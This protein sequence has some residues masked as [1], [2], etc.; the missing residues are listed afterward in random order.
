[1]YKI[2]LP[3]LCLIIASSVA[4]LA[5][6][7]A[8]CQAPM[9]VQSAC[10]LDFARCER[11]VRPERNCS[12]K[13]SFPGVK[14]DDP[15]CLA[16]QQSAV[17]LYEATKEQCRR[18]VSA[19][20]ETCLVE[21]AAQ[22]YAAGS[23]YLACL[24]L[25]SEQGAIASQLAVDFDRA[26][27]ELEKLSIPIAVPASVPLKLQTDMNALKLKLY[28]TTEM[29]R[30]I[31]E[32]RTPDQWAG[33]LKIGS[34]IIIED[35]IFVTGAKSSLDTYELVAATAWVKKFRTLGSAFFDQLASHRVQLESEVLSETL[36][37]CVKLRC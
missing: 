23:K 12:V 8:K 13:F 33:G 2:F 3:A 6:S 17:A 22:K 10:R 19:E 28:R 21:E 24:K 37:Q 36:T 1:M 25:R 29:P 5:Q 15:L 20:H 32:P 18:T 31:A 16:A 7:E 30:D 11:L 27:A 4:T 35:N 14:V 26:K 34:T 9:E